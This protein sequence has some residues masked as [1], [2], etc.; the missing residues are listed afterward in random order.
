MSS[1]APSAGR[2]RC[3]LHRSP[4]RRCPRP[5]RHRSQ[6]RLRSQRR[7]PR[8]WP[9][10]RPCRSL[11]S[12]RRPPCRLLPC[13]SAAALPLSPQAFSASANAAAKN[14]DTNFFI[15]VPYS[16]M[17]DGS[18]AVEYSVAKIGFRRRPIQAFRQGNGGA[19]DPEMLAQRRQVYM[20]R[21]ARETRFRCRHRAALKGPAR[22]RSS[23]LRRSPRSRRS[24]WPAAASA[25]A[26]RC[27]ARRA[28]ARNES[29]ADSACRRRSAADRSLPFAS[30]P[31]R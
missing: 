23:R 26:D 1:R 11:P 17:K 16:C 8:P 28:A 15:G 14:T 25:P 12:R 5:W 6:Q 10:P 18:S 20:P 19:T 2:R 22:F 4:S 29:D 21:H 7:C 3:G 9:R 30:G 13:A 31:V 24:G 27:P